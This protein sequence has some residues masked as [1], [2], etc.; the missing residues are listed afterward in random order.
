MSSQRP[1][2]W[3]AVPAFAFFAL[4]AALPMVLV[5]YLSFTAWDGL[6]TPQLNGG[7]NWSRLLDDSEARASVWRTLL[8][9]VM[10]WL[11]QTPIALLVGVWA[12][13]KQ[14][15]R[16]VLSSIFFLPLLLSTAAIALLWQALL[17][18][19]FGAFVGGP[20]FLGDPDIALYTVVL[21]IS[22]QFIPFHTL[23]YQGAARAVPP[24]LYEAATLDGA[25]RVGKFLHI[26]LPQLRYTI[27]TSSVLMLVGSLTTFDTVLILTN[28]GPGTATRILPLHMYITGFSGFEMGY[29]S[30]IAV[31]LV[32]LGT[33][34]SIAVMRWSG[35]RS[36]SSQQEGS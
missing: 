32:V 16:A 31:V 7:E 18:P 2:A 4:F 5:I 13:G 22:W 12:A 10:S 15:S 19:N 29:A 1:S 34:L 9:M 23:L 25:T 28:G 17:E 35:F 33:A 3:Y 24:S 8:L 20:L 21:V 27:V 30:A 6:G 11:V 26:T 36:M 14:R